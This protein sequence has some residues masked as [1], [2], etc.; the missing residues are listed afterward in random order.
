MVQI[1]VQLLDMSMGEIDCGVGFS[2]F[3]TSEYVQ[4]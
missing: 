1:P 2:D 4:F 3:V